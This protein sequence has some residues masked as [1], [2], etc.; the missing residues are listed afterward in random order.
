MPSPS[1][2]TFALHGR[3][4]VWRRRRLLSQNYWGAW[5]WVSWTWAEITGWNVSYW[6]I[7]RYWR[8][9][10]MHSV[11]CWVVLCWWALFLASLSSW[12]LLCTRLGRLYSLCG[13]KLMHWLGSITLCTWHFLASRCDR[14]HPMSSRLQLSQL[15][16]QLHYTLLRWIV[17]SPWRSKLYWLSC[18]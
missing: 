8:D 3:L 7:F 5:D 9:Q 2:I 4:T 6:L 14:M 16:W 18:W 10:H 11:S 17:Q 13:R 12:H 15:G 1:I